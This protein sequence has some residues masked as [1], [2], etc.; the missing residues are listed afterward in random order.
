MS[1]LPSVP[2]TYPVFINCRDRLA[3]LRT[4]VEW[5][6]Q[7]GSTEVYLLDNDSAYEPLLDYYRQT[8]HTVV[9]LGRNWGKNALWMAPGVFDLTRNRR[10]VYTDP[11]IVPVEEC[12]SDAVDRFSEL[13]DRYLRVNKAGFG[14]A[15]DDI[16]ASYR[17]REAA[18][19][20]ERRMW[21]WPIETG[22]YFAP[23]DTMFALYRAGA[24]RVPQDAVRTG[25]PYLARHTAYYL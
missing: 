4:L 19:N 14:I 15:M 7:A 2:T 22:A 8:P 6:E 9:R 12:P 20:W 23:H 18:L 1:M 13:L 25:R 11:D 3:P 17:H 21:E 16:P 10:F 5:L 24:P